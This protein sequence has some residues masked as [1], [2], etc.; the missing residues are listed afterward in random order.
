MH[1]RYCITYLNAQGGEKISPIEI[2]NILSKHE[3]V[4]EAVS[5]AVPDDMY[6]EAV[7]AAII[8]HDTHRD[9]VNAE[10][11]KK[12]M[13]ENVAAFKVPTKVSLSQST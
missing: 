10:E 13:R 12:W 4:N 6:G 5:F 9:V 11:L 3:A 1:A 8:L 2:D 7:G